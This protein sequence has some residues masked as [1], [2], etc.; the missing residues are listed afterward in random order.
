MWKVVDVLRALSVPR[1][2]PFVAKQHRNIIK[3]H[4]L[5]VLIMD[6]MTSSGRLLLR[7]HVQR[8]PLNIFRET[9][10]QFKTLRVLM[11]PS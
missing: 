8:I 11:M 4:I 9:L 3:L 6:A 7:R 2:A 10:P 5:H 1:R